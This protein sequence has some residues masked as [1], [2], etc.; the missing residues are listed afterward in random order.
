M[1]IAAV[2]PNGYCAG[3]V[4]VCQFGINARKQPKADMVGQLGAE[5]GLSLHYPPAAPV[6]TKLPFAVVAR[7]AAVVVS[8]LAKQDPL[9]RRRSR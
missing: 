8:Q 3:K 9:R 4:T 5:S 7:M 2:T 1:T 6:R